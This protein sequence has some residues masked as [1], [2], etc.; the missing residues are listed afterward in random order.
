[1]SKARLPLNF[2]RKFACANLTSAFIV[3]GFKEVFMPIVIAP[4]NVLLK[5]TKLVL[6]DR[7]KKHMENLG[8]TVNGSIEV[9]SRSGG[10]VICL[11]KQGRLAL[12]RNIATRILVTEAKEEIC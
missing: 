12:D 6:D 5:I 7:T 8:I 3:I 9:V 1:M 4:V 10:S 2:I 11:V